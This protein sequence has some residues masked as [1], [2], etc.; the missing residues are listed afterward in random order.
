LG[1]AERVKFHPNVSQDE[2]V[3]FYNAAD[4]LVLASTNEGLPNV[5]LEAISCGTPVV[6][7]RVGGIPEIIRNTAAG[8][9]VDDR[10]PAT[11]C[12]AIEDVINRPAQDRN[13]LRTEVADFD[14]AR[15]SRHLFDLFSKVL[16]CGSRR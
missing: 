9:L 1:V 12:R 6:G 16:T 15:T 3:N 11:L 14:W 2:L 5:I 4:V 7:T 13:R 10:Q 8:V